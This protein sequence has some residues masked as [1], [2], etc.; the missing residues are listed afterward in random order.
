[1]TDSNVGRP[2]SKQVERDAW[3]SNDIA[4]RALSSVFVD[5]VGQLNGLRIDTP[6]SALGLR[7]VDYVLLADRAASFFGA[8]ANLLSDDDFAEIS[9]VSDMLRQLQ[10]DANEG[11][12]C[13]KPEVGK[14]GN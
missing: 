2:F 10:I 5:V 1:M 6:L 4:L 12:F 9:T 14:H 7:S 8:R 13:D 3:E 11:S